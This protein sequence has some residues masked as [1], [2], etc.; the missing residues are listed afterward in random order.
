MINFLIYFYYPIY[1]TIPTNDIAFN[2][3]LSQQ[4]L[5]KYNRKLKKNNP[6]IKF[7]IST[8]KNKYFIG[9]VIEIEMLFKNISKNEYQ[10]TNRSYDRSGRMSE[11]EFYGDGSDGLCEDPRG[12][13]SCFS[14]GMGTCE[15]VTENKRKFLLNKWI[16]FRKPGKYYIYSSNSLVADHK[17]L[18][19]NIIKLNYLTSNI[20]ELNIVTPPERFTSRLI[21]N[22]L[23]KI[24]HYDEKIKERGF[25]ELGFI[26]NDEAF[27]ELLS[28]P[29]NMQHQLICAIAHKNWDFI[30]KTLISLL[31]NNSFELDKGYLFTLSYVSTPKEIMDKY[32]EKF[33][34]LASSEDFENIKNKYILLWEEIEEIKNKY[35]KQM[36]DKIKNHPRMKK[37]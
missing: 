5:D 12:L 6:D 23:I 14:G 35:K 2:Y 13:Y 8:I 11:V 15:K 7:S 18:T 29:N 10:I 31:D 32:F 28:Y 36:Y 4:F 27:L 37:E 22:A 24:N 17:N 34:E 1:P 16:V 9:E 21:S 20:L 30:R 19:P 3:K 33:K 26:A 25:L